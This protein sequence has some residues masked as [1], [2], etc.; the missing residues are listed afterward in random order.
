MDVFQQHGEVGDGVALWHGTA[1]GIDV[2]TQQRDFFHALIGQV[3]DINQHIFKGARYFG[4][5]RVGHHANAALLAAAFHDGYECRRAVD[6]CQRQTVDFFDYR[7]ADVHLRLAGVL[8]LPDQPGQAVQCLG[9]QDHVDIWC[10]P[11]DGLAFLAG[12]AAAHTD[13]QVRT[14][15]FELAHAPQIGKDFFL[16]FFTHRTGVEKDDV[17]VV[18]R[19]GELDA[20]FLVQDVDHLVRIVFVHLAPEGADEKLARLAG[21][22]GAKAGGLVRVRCDGPGFGT[23]HIGSGPFESGFLHSDR[24]DGCSSRGQGYKNSIIAAPYGTGPACASVAGSAQLGTRVFFLDGLD[25]VFALDAQ[26]H[27]DGSGDK[28]G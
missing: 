23:G 2:L 24:R 21:V 16:G 17:G 7:K 1:V 9:P 10:A 6:P 5:T 25:Q 4:T 22:V 27:G 20:D 26:P 13:D 19:T 18:G 14:L 15:L 11:D 28:D 3:G 12:H 8:A